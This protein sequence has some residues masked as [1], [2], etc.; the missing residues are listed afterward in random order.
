MRSSPQPSAPCAAACCASAVVPARFAKTSMRSPLARWHSSGRRRVRAR[1]GRATVRG[2]RG[3]RTAPLAA[4]VTCSIPASASRISAAPSAASLNAGPDAD[5]HGNAEGA[6]EDRDMRGRT[7]RHQRDTRQPRRV[8]V[9]EL[10]RR[11]IAGHQDAARR[12]HGTLLARTRQLAQHLAFEIGE[13]AD[14]L[15]ESRVA[16]GVQ[17][18]DA[19]V[20]CW[21]ARQSPRSCHRVSRRARPPAA[22][23][24][25][26]TRDAPAECRAAPARRR[27]RV[28]RCAYGPRP[29]RARGRRFRLRHRR[30]LRAR[31]FRRISNFAAGPTAKPR[32]AIT[33]RRRPGSL[34]AGITTGALAR[35]AA[36]AACA[37]GSSSRTTRAISATPAAAAA[38]KPT[39]TSSSP[40]R[41]PS[42]ISATALCGLALRPRARTSR[43]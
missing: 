1:R 28:G 27:V 42:D 35:G 22:A 7:A 13:I 16:G 18:S 21:R 26:A 41:T 20:R 25:R 4:G 10:R 6:G 3:P 24:R 33:P 14:A 31:R 17:A 38:S 39:M 5:Q 11:E 30:R 12:D 2:A 8:D 37:A 40:P 19:V 43:R 34:L 9:D 15:H 36:G 29:A 23:G 32:L